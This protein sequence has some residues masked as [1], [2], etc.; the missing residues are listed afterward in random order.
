MG[1]RSTV[2]PCHTTGHSDPHPAVR[3]IELRTNEQTWKTQRIK[4]GDAKGVDHRWAIGDTER[5]MYRSSPLCGALGAM[6]RFGCLPP[7]RLGL[8]NF[9]SPWPRHRAFGR[10]DFEFEP[11]VIKPVMLVITRCPAG[12]LRPTF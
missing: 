9:R 10:V 6:H 8:G 3:W 5:T 1:G 7:L 4:V 12:S 2:L 11:R